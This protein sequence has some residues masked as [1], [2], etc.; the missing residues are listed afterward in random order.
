MVV[1]KVKKII[2]I[3]VGLLISIWLILY[4]WAM[5]LP[6]A[7]SP[8]GE[9]LSTE[10]REVTSEGIKRNE[11]ILQRIDND[12][13]LEDLITRSISW[14]DFWSHPDFHIFSEFDALIEIGSEAIHRRAELYEVDEVFNIEVL[15]QLD[16]G[17]IYTVFE[18]GRRGWMFL[19]F[20]QDKDYQLSH[21]AFV[22]QSLVEKDFDAIS[23]GSPIENYGE[24]F[25]F[26]WRNRAWFGS[27]NER[28]RLRYFLL[29]D[30]LIIIHLD[31]YQYILEIERRPDKRIYLP[32]GTELNGRI[33]E[34]D[35]VFDFNILPQDFPR[36]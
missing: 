5:T 27:H 11:V 3:I 18:V 24:S 7:M 1:G 32:A 35:E 19:F 33:L 36:R 4:F 8:T 2:I 26:E 17:N 15:R 21:M 30:T 20:S 22:N 16:S 10:F 25:N 9:N 12:S 28:H 29:E 13:P 23:V 34:E 14:T 31:D 6:R